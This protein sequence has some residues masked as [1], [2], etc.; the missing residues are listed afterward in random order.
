LGT[1][2]ERIEKVV[3]EVIGEALPPAESPDG[4]GAPAGVSRGDRPVALASDHAGFALK[5]S[6]RRYM[7]EELGLAVRDL[8]PASDA[9]CDYPD[10]AALVGRAVAGGEC[11]GGIVID[12]AG[13]GSAIAANKIAGVRAACCHDVATAVNSRAHNDA[14]VLTMGAGVVGRGLARQMVRVWLG[15]EFQGGRH[16]RRVAKIEALEKGWTAKS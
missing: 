13:I 4:V 14:N 16:G 6:L 8:G 10:Y 7:V 2:R 11:R 12:G 1:D 9:P 5:E 3:R 15:T